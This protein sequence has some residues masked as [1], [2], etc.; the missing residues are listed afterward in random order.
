V[1]TPPYSSMDGISTQVLDNSISSGAFGK[2]E[3]VWAFLGLGW[4]WWPMRLIEEEPENAAEG[5]VVLK[6]VSREDF[7]DCT[8]SCLRP[9]VSHWQE[10]TSSVLK[11]GAQRSITK[12]VL[13]STAAFHSKYYW[14]L[15]S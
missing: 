11:G 12:L 14:T 13:A 1:L 2:G 3:L 10:I 7:S 8:L 15:P 6:S 9:L 4:G 5:C